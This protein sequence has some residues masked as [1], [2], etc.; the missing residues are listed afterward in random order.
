VRRDNDTEIGAEAEKAK[1]GLRQGIEKSKVL[2]A[3]YRARLF[4]LR[5]AE[6]ARVP[7]RPLFRFES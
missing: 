3:Q 1:I 4:V 7:E 6:T 2:V 5:R